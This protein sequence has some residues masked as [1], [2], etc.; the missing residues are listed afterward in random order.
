LPDPTTPHLTV[1]LR[2]RIGA[3]NIDVA[4]QLTHP[5]TILFGPSGSGKTT[6]LRAIAGLL[7]PDF[8][9]IA[10]DK[11]FTL[12]DTAAGI[13]LPPHQRAIPLAPQQPSLFPNMTV[14][15][16]LAYGA[17]RSVDANSLSTFRIEHI[18]DKHPTDLSGGE[19]QRATLARTVAATGH[20]LLLLDEPFTGLDLNLRDELIANLLAWQQ[21]HR[22]PILSVTHGIAEAF[23][24]N[25][26]VIKLSEGRIL[27]QGPA[28]T[29]LAEDRSR[30]LT[31]LNPS[32]TTQPTPYIP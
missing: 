15:E 14:R 20:R 4:F 11:S 12:V 19:A 18:A 25:A 2:H 17:G 27:A 32:L 16:N 6:I 29:V 21:E 7:R 3:L 24:L 30:L 28:A 9:H 13:F 31:Q 10:A 23:Q 1:Q 5:W 26:E 8:A 22:T